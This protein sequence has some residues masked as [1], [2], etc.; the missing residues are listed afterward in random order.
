MCSGMWP[1]RESSRSV[2]KWKSSVDV[3]ARKSELHN[4]AYAFNLIKFPIM[5][6]LEMHEGDMI[7]KEISKPIKYTMRLI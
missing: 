2:W 5:V 6:V 3:Q 4:S 1:S 7:A